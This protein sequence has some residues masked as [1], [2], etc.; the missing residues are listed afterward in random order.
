MSQFARAPDIQPAIRVESVLLR[1]RWLVLVLVIPVAWI[2]SNGGEPFPPAFIGWLVALCLYNVVIWAILHFV[3]A[4]S[5][6]L[7]TVTLIGDMVFFGVLPYAA[8]SSGNLLAFFSIFPALAASIRFGPFIGLV[9]AG[10]L[11]LPIGV[12]AVLPI[13]TE[14]TRAAFPAGLPIAALL[15]AAAIAGYLAK[16]EREAAVKQAVAELEDL[17]HAMAGAKMLYATSDNLSSTAN[18]APILEAMLEA[19]VKGLPPGRREDG[20]PAGIALLFDE[21][22]EHKSLKIVAS[23]H[24]DR[25]DIDRRLAGKQG[26]VAE[27]LQSGEP[28]IF[29]DVMKD[30]ELSSLG[31]LARCRSGVCYPLQAGLDQYGVVVLAGPAPRRPSDQH[32]EL[33]RAFTNQA[34]LAFQNAKLYANLR[35]EHDQVINTE[36]EMRQKL[37]RDLH[38]GPTQKVAGLVMQLDYINKLLDR[39]VETARTELEKARAVAEQTVK[40]IRTALFTLRPLALE[41][42]GLSAAL[43]GLCERLQSAENVPITVDPGNFGTELDLNIATTVFSIIDEAV[44]NARKHAAGVPIFIQVSRQKNTLVAVVQDQGPGFDL[45]KVVSS[46]DARSS[47]GLQNMRERAKLIDGDLRIDSERGRGTRVMLIVPLG[48]PNG[49]QAKT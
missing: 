46:Y 49:T 36:N 2:D 12:R 39:D 25:R 35:A 6:R 45:N 13:S 5:S 17:R 37:A 9:V 18:Y 26:I 27:A 8:G 28:A 44:G 33:M 34:A 14:S 32:L 22:D 29:D 23:R 47:L 4:P 20:L 42:K 16:H 15:A 38:D 43:E 31:A 40:E 3:K 11:A 10:L 30:P 1:I 24:L 41:T 21:G 48:N 7:P 19:G